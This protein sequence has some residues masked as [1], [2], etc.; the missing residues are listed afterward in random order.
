MASATLLTRQHNPVGMKVITINGSPRL[1]GNTSNILLDIQD[2]LE[3]DGIEVEQISLYSHE[4]DPCNDCRSCMLRGDGVCIIEDG[5]NELANKM[6]EADGIIMASPCYYGAC[7]SQMKLFMERVGFPMENGDMGLKRKVG[8]AVVVNAHDG[9]TLVY[10]QI[11]DWML[12]N[13]MI[14]VGG[15]PLPILRAINSPQYLDDKAGMKG[16]MS[17]VKEMSWLIQ[18]LK[19]E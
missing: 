6:R 15:T 5:L 16:L 19:K 7:S 14:V 17:M 9:G 18:T 3:K 11:V 8:A 1:V 12:R 2:E 13:Q 10:S 4:F